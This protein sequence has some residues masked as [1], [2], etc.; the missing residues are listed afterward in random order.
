MTE[1]NEVQIKLAEQ[2]LLTIVNKEMN[3]TYKELA[4]RIDP[5]IHHRQIG[6]NIGVI[7][8][9]CAE[10]RLPLLSAKVVNATSNS[11]GNGFF[12][13]FRL[14][15]I[16]TD[17]L[18]EGELGKRERQRIRDCTDWQVLSDHLQL[19][20]VFETKGSDVS[21]Q[22]EIRLLPMSKE[23]EFPNMDYEDVQKTFFLDRLIKEQRG[24]YYYPNSGL[25]CPA[26]SLVLFQFKN[27]II[28]SAIILKTDILTTSQKEI[29]KGA[30]VFD[31]DSIK[32][33]TPISAKE[34]STIYPSFKGFSQS[35]QKLDYTKIT[36]ILNLIDKKQSVLLPEELS[37]LEKEKYIEGAKRL[38]TINAYERNDKARQECIQAHGYTCQIC[39][40]NFGEIYGDVFDGKIHVHHIK[41]LS[42]INSSY[43]V[44]PVTDL[45]PV[46]PNCHMV[47]HAKVGGAYTVEE[48][49]KFLYRNNE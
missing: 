20:I 34:I 17:N 24:Y 18:S 33:F 22:K 6:R 36:D 23:D 37:L 49:K 31:I 40:F 41:P 3:V 7:S 8:I 2:L 11:V 5:P 14:S 44:N 10:L 48:V 26:G 39:G 45:I 27:E 46:C 13:I 19:D 35:K 9:L 4:E 25:I 21:S 12:E 30:F 43:K 47:L 42:E 1:L 38:I 32:V 29:Y 15:G 16:P 28:A